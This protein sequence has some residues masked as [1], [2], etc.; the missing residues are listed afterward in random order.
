MGTAAGSNLDLSFVPTPDKPNVVVRRLGRGTV[1]IARVRCDADGLGPL[2]TPVI[3]DAFLV[4]HHLTN[5]RSDIWVDGKPVPKPRDIAG[6]T[7]IHDFRRTITCVMHTAFDTMTF[8]LPR[9]TLETALPDSRAGRLED[10]DIEPSRPV[11]DPAVAALVAAMLP[12]LTMPERISLLM[13]DHLSCAL[14]THV[15]TAYGRHSAVRNSGT[16]APWQERR[17]KEMIAARLDGEIRLADLA[18]ECRLSVGHFARA[19]RQSTNTTPHQWLLQRRIEHAKTLMQDRARTLAAI[20]LDCGFADQSHFTRTFNRLV[21]VTPRV[22]R[23]RNAVAQDTP[24]SGVVR[25]TADA[26]AF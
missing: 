4:S 23:H 10:L 8:H 20:A 24:H 25:E 3:E 11:E 18:A 12:A 22:W 5:F 16:L 17:A 6:L 15:V 7:T 26:P 9:A 14:A 1:G 19:F 13:L 21:G 2:D